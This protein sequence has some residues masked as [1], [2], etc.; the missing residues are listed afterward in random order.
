MMNPKQEFLR[1]VRAEKPI[2]W[3]GYG[4]E[5]FPKI[6]F[7]CVIDPI[8]IWD[9]LWIQGE[10]VVD[11][12][13]VVH[14]YLPGDHGII[15][16]VTEENQVIKDITRWRD[17]VH[18]PEIPADLDW[19][20][21]KAS[22]AE[23]DRERELIMLPMFRGL[24]ER[25]HC[26]MTFENALVALYE[27]PEACNAFFE[28]YTDW[29]LKVAEQLIDNLQPDIIHSHDDLGSRDRLFFSPQVFR[30]LFKSHYAR[31]YAYCKKRGVL[32]QHHADC[33][34]TGLEN[35]FIDMGADMWQG[36]LPSN[37]IALI[38]KNTKGKLLLMGG[39]DQAV[40][41]QAEGDVT[42]EE[43][44]A[45]VRRAIDAYAPAGSF[46]PCIGS[47]ACINE[48]VNPIVIDECNRYGAEWVKKNA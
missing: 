11:H 1:M 37:D 7:H 34:C 20:G 8:T 12:W 48:W 17:C 13:G 6:A 2:R 3:M 15:P 18:F 10:S 24:F 19:S 26:L 22:I 45:E 5:A 42:E 16:T 38:Q 40:I 41:D 44:R 9:I 27:E 46:L 30:D 21:A 39:L 36:V 35:D 31:L 28:A 33:Y 25:L 14:R 47:I 43:I 23:I 29:K 32:V 4:F